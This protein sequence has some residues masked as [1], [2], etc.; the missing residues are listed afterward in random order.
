MP[1]ARKRRVTKYAN[2]FL[3]DQIC[4]GVVRDIKSGKF[5]IGSRLPSLGELAENY[6]ASRLTV[7]RAL[8]KLKIRGVLYSVPAQ[9]TYVLDAANGSEE[10][11]GGIVIALCSRIVDRFNI[12]AYH[13]DIIRGIQ[14]ALIPR[15]GSLTLLPLSQKTTSTDMQNRADAAI[16]IGDYDQKR[17]RALLESGMPTILVDSAPSEHPVDTITVDNRAGGAMLIRHLHSQGHRQFAAITGLNDAPCRDRLL[18]IREQIAENGGDPDKQLV[19]IEGN[20][21]REGGFAAMSRI[22]KQKPA[23][24]ALIC[25]NDDTAAGALQYLYANTDLQVPR[26]ISIA[27]FDNINIAEATH[28]SLT[29]VHI[30]R[31]HMG[32]LSVEI[33]ADRLEQRDASPVHVSVQT[34]L[35]VRESTGPC[36]TSAVRRGSSDGAVRDVVASPAQ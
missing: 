35:V 22:L 7:L 8:N 16:V 15:H 28:P 27:G 20:Y 11:R 14:E 29:T 3:Y 26:D 2:K 32:R 12:G 5:P 18:G 36:P 19:L 4:E 10:A 23:F 13:S 9:G 34:R 17:I 1:M 25:F 24:T 33:L 21:T 31:R 6:K 30:D